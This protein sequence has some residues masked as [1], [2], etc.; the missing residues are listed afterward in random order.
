MNN[1][2]LA[3]EETI[4]IT[5]ILMFLLAIVFSGCLTLMT[6]DTQDQE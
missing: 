1:N 3:L 5:A 6:S 2:T 4:A